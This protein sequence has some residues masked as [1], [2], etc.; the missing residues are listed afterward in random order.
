MNNESTNV[1]NDDIKS[2][3]EAGMRV[4]LKTV[5]KR[6]LQNMS[7]LGPSNDKD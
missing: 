7:S 2:K 3:W 6:L 5:R 4:D 1:I